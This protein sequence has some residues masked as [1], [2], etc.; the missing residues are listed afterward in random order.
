MVKM[1]MKTWGKSA[2]IDL[3][4]CNHELITNKMYIELFAKVL[5]ERIDM[6]PYGEPTVVWFGNSG[7]EGFSLVQLIETSCIT[8]HFSETDD[9][10]YIDVF[11]CK[12]FDP[13]ECAAICKQY[14]DAEIIVG[15]NYHD[16]GI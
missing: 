7:K 13:T 15:F 10:A 5:C 16:R 11:S 4:R 9:T 8:A 12:D 14:F 2:H 1:V 6:I 3:M